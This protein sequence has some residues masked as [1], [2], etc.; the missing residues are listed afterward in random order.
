VVFKSRVGLPSSNIKRG[1]LVEFSNEEGGSPGLLNGFTLT[2][3]SFLPLSKGTSMDTSLPR[4]FSSIPI[5]SKS[6]NSTFL[7]LSKVAT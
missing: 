4:K 6:S 7:E 2:S 3:I 5:D 1:R